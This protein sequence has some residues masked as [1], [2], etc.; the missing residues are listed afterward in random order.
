MIAFKKLSGLP[1]AMI[2]VTALISP[3]LSVAAAPWN[4]YPFQTP[5]RG[6]GGEPGDLSGIELIALLAPCDDAARASF[7]EA[8]DRFHAGLPPGT[9]FLVVARDGPYQQ[10]YVR[11]DQIVDDVIYGHMDSNVFVSG[12]GYAKGDS[13]NLSSS[14]IVDWLISYPDRPEE[15]NLAGKY[16]VRLDDGLVSGPCDAQH[17]ELTRFR[18]Y[19]PGY[20]FMPPVTE[21]WVLKEGDRNA[22]VGSQRIDDSLDMIDTVFSDRMRVRKRSAGMT[23]QE[24]ADYIEEIE[25][26]NLGDPD[27]YTL[28]EHAVTP[29][30]GQDKR[31]VTARQVIEDREALSPSGGRSLKIREI[32]ELVCFHPGDDRTLVRLSYVH[33][34]PVG[35]GRAEFQDQ[36]FAMF[37]TLSFSEFETL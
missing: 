5:N 19:Q 23:I 35:Q 29:L 37:D 3:Q 8:V 28:L 16:I 18:V 14:E 34:H 20:S 26:E 10:Y 32:M 11:V 12:R 2:G 4:P 31:C 36:A 30:T 13:Y 33:T 17:P 24:F 25:R 27:R 9:D 7:P 15:G 21:G 22:D 1:V 6:Y